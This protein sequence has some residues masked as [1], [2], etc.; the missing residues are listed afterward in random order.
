MSGEAWVLVA[1]IVF[2]VVFIW[3]MDK[4]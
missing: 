1:M 4:A 3:G 2:G